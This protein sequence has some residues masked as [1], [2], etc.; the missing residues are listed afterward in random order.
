MIR[1]V[2]QIA[3]MMLVGSLYSLSQT[4]T[5]TLQGLVQDE[6][7][8]VVSG[9]SVKVINTGTNETKELQTD[10][11]G[12]YVVPFLTPGNYTVSIQAAGFN[13]AK[14]DNVTINVSQTR[15]VDFTLKVGAIS[16]QVEV[17]ASA[18]PLDTE[19]AT[20][21]QVIDTKKVVDLPLNGRNP[22]SLASL[23]PGVNNVGGASTPHIGGSRNAVNEEQLD[24]MTNILPENNVGNNVSAYTPIVD[25]VQEFSVQTNSLSAEY[26]RF[27]G[28]VINLVTKSGTNNWHGGLFEFSRNSV[29]NANDFFANRAGEGKPSSNERQYG[30]TLGGP[31]AIPKIYNGHNRSFFFFG[32]QGDNAGTAS[33]ATE[34]VPTQAFRNGDFSS[35]G[36]TIY[37]PLSVH[38]DPATGNFV[39]NAFAN[40]IIPSNLFDPVAVKA[41][42]F[43]PLPNSGGPNAQTNNYVA[44]GNNTGNTY[45]WDSRIDH[46]FSDNWHTFFRL[47][48]SWSDSTPLFPYGPTNPAS[49]VG[50]G[51]VV[52]GAWSVSLDSTFTINPT[53]VADFRYGFARSYVTDKPLGAGFDVTSLGLPQ[54]LQTLASQRVA[55]FPNFNFSNG[56][57]LGSTGYVALVE[58]PLAHDITG[59]LTKITAH[60]TIKLGG[61]WRK[62]FI[63]FSQ[64]GFPSG[65][66]NFDQTW[67]QQVLNKSNGT[68]SPFASFLLGLP[69]G[70]QVTEEPTAADAST[71]MALYV[72]DDWK[73]T[74]KLTLNLG[75]RWD[76][77]FPRTE[78]FNR[79][80]YWNPNLPSSIQGKIPA[81]ACLYCAD[82]RGQMIFVGT[83]QSMYG[84]HQ[85]PTQWKDFGPRFGIAY[86]PT[87]KMVFRGG[88]GIS[89]AP[90]ALQAAGTTGA[91]GVQGF[92]TSTNVNSSFT[93][94]QTINA[95]LSNPFPQGFNLPLGPAG[96]P[97]T[98]LGLGIG[99]SFF[100]SYR[101][102]YSIEWN[103]NIQ[104]Q[105]P[106]Q[107]TIEV[108]Y[109]A[110][111]GLFLVD[112]EV[113]QPYSQ[114][115]PVYASLGN[116]LLAQVPNPFFGV[117]TTPGSPLSQP[118]VSLNRLL[119]PF[120]QYDGVSS[121][122][123]PRADSFYN[124][125][126]ARL[127]KRFAN[128]LTFLVSFTG[129]KSM[130]NSAAAVG[131]LGP[132]SGTRADQYNRRLEW[133]VSPQDISKSLVMSFVYN[134]PF[135]KG[136]KLLNSSPRVANLLVAGWQVNGILTFQTGTPI[137]VGGALNQ[138]G[139]LTA[140]Q[141]PDNSGQPAK[142]SH[143]T[144]NEWFNTS[145]FLQPPPFT[146]GNTSR[147]L[148]DVRTP[149]ESNAD[150]SLFKNNYFGKE[151]RYNLQF[152]IEAFNALNHPQFGG[153]NSS[154]QSGAAFGTITSLAIP[155][156]IVQLAAKFNF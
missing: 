38:L 42:S 69:S 100:D 21:G 143:Q 32:F 81:N 113:G 152:R 10:S 72:Q 23:V 89:Y 110:N 133:S 116:Q 55:E 1:R 135:G 29:L 2:C 17:Q 56:S 123:K 62:M 76:V 65:Q 74:Q 68:G 13:S 122:R 36:T 83:P 71:Y 12:R 35:L 111:R 43:F 63:N 109:I 147:T 94:Q 24:G 88:F 25:S 7:G 16:E 145:V 79:L 87:S 136:Q 57:N 70:G 51:F 140:N 127:D 91:P 156:R 108:G 26:G 47:S 146:I 99:E 20:T 46:N 45:Q 130:D 73:V 18:T 30:G 64:Y 53:T 52:G 11:S 14:E 82:L 138:T 139:L 154:I 105:L 150:I 144:I 112:G 67:T 141:R 98:N 115:S 95:T 153:P 84:R 107:M 4:P 97:A 129:G 86:T 19:T 120:P 15:S 104:R 93:S 121:F 125:V 61:E 50:S 49:P 102:P 8:G 128:G 149:G 33:I 117:I 44:V 40:N 60:Q 39:R 78:R 66:F 77:D 6:S 48:H 132:I 27:G 92:G 80:S 126:I 148:P 137:V 59:S 31:I 41:L 22:F 106:G 34:T 114:V 131:Y 155:S 58:N 54:S 5:G 75:L 151:S 142:L 134:L 103:F 119:R 101:N 124:G 28:G 3:A 85:G 90:S 37:D 96:G 9:A 118:T